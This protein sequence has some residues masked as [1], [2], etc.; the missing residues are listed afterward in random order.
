MNQAIASGTGQWPG[1]NPF[2]AVRIIRGE[3]GSPHLPFLP[4]LPQRGAGADAVGRTAALLAGLPVDVQPYGWRLVPMPG[5][6][7]KRAVS[8]LNSD[9]NAMADVIGAEEAP[10]G[11]LKIQ[12][13]GPLSLAANLYLH[14]GERALSDHGARRDILQSLSAGMG[15]HI[16][17]VR[18]LSRGAAMVVQVD[19]PD[20]GQVLAGT[21]PTASGYRTLRSVPEQEV[22]AA[23]HTLAGAARK[24][25]AA[26][27]VLNGPAAGIPLHKLDEAGADAAGVDVQG[28]SMTQ[29]EGL[30]GAVEAGRRV[31]LRLT[32][33]IDGDQK[34]ETG[35]SA[36]TAP[37]SPDVPQ[38]SSLAN[39]VLE[40]WRRLG[41]PASQLRQLVLLPASSMAA[42]GPAQARKVVARLTSASD[43]LNQVAAE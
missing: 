29:W 20:I 42:V 13:R 18:Q 24:A 10:G 7:L 8:L 16:A 9:I 40:P 17:K 2:E 5:R 33:A 6:D 43:A 34:A 15:D 27:V 37:Q 23:W 28:L 35:K 19:E 30:A 11:M 38:V 41:M 12:L 25:G 14:H 22:L 4:E 1:T 3:L 26:D 39:Q 32:T 36:E 21:I 31:W